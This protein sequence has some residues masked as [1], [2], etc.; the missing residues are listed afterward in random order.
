MKRVAIL[1]LL[2]LS[3]AMAGSASATPASP[4]ANVSKSGVRVVAKAKALSVAEKASINGMDCGCGGHDDPAPAPTDLK[5]GYGFGTTGHYGPP[6]QDFTPAQ[7]WRNWVR[8]QGHTD[9]T[10]AG[11]P[12]PGQ[13]VSRQN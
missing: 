10:P 9:F 12:L 2:S 5:P 1:G 13:A 7:S 11:H 6:G 3:A 4:A 8:V